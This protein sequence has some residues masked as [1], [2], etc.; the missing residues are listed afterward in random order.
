MIMK[1]YALRDIKVGYLSPT[2]HDSDPIA[3]RS[4]ENVL[5]SPSSSLLDSH[6]EDFSLFCLGEFDTKTGILSPFNVPE[7]IVEVKNLL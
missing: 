2:I 1:V 6:P 3:I 5:R 4:I 7:L